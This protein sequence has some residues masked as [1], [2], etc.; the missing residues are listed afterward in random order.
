MTYKEFCIM[1]DQA[2]REVDSTYR[3]KVNII[4]HRV[5]E[6]NKEVGFYGIAGMEYKEFLEAMK[7]YSYEEK[8]KIA[9]AL[10]QH[11]AQLD[12]IV[13]DEEGEA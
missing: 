9:Y 11:I 2:K 13:F 10:L 3:K 6:L 5:Y 1:M 7:G 8:M 12:N 4:R